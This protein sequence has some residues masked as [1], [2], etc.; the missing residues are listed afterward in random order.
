MSALSELNKKPIMERTALDNAVLFSRHG[1]V[2][3]AAAELQALR[4]AVV[5]TELE[6]LLLATK[7][8]MDADREF[9]GKCL[10]KSLMVVKDALAALEKARCIS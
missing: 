2:E 6:S 4:G 1:E 8:N 7:Y 5:T 10:E 9:A 3:Q